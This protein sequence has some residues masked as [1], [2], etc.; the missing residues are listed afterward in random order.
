MI[1]GLLGSSLLGGI[2][3]G[4]VVAGLGGLV[5]LGSESKIEKGRRDR[6][7]S[8]VQKFAESIE[9]RLINMRLIDQILPRP[10]HFSLTRTLSAGDALETMAEWTCISLLFVPTRKVNIGEPTSGEPW[11]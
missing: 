3:A 9:G 6:I 5:L 2:K 7:V 8:V 4:S 11:G 1:G 10:S